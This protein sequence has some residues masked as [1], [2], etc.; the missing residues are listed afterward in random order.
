M[1]RL[2]APNDLAAIATDSRVWVK[3]SEKRRS[4]RLPLSRGRGLSGFMRRANFKSLRISAASRCSIP[5]REPRAGFIVAKASCLL[6]F[7]EQDFLRVVDLA[8]FDLNNLIFRRR[9]PSSD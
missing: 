5:S 1:R 4:P 6:L 9:H 2:K 8:K 3:A 7:H